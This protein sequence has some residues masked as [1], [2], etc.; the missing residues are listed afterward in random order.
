MGTDFNNLFLSMQEGIEFVK[1]C[2]KIFLENISVYYL[3]K[4]TV[5]YYFIIDSTILKQYKK[6]GT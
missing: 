5:K 4:S 2:V 6:K 1:Y 3:C